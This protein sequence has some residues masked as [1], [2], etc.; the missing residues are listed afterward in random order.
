MASRI[1]HFFAGAFIGAGVGFLFAPK[2][3]S[4]TKEQL[5]KSFENLVETIKSI[6]IEE[7]KKVY[8]KKIQNFKE[9]IENMDPSEM[10]KLLKEKEKII[11]KECDKVIQSA[12]ANNMTL[13]EEKAK[14]MQN[15]THNFTENLTKEMIK[16]SKN[17]KHK[18]KKKR[19]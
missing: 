5:E 18:K 13:V 14:T 19:V 1:R 3:G 8:E 2:E 15:K 7:T 17:K 4:K 11:D 6:D 16:S 10:E 12:K 9:K